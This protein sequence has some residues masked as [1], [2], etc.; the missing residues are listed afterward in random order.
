MKEDDSSHQVMDAS[1]IAEPRRADHRLRRD[2][3]R[4]LGQVKG[5]DM[6]IECDDPVLAHWKSPNGLK[7]GSMLAGKCEGS[8]SNETLNDK[9]HFGRRG[10]KPAYRSESAWSTRCL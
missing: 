6:A 4:W 8:D 2:R 7:A 1:V 9:C 10:F 3:E 5:I